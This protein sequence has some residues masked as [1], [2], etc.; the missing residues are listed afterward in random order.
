MRTEKE[1]QQEIQRLQEMLISWK[2]HSQ[3]KGP[4]RDFIREGYDYNRMSHYKV[5][6]VQNIPG[7]LPITEVLEELKRSFLPAVYPYQFERCDYSNKYNGWMVQVSNYLQIN[8][9]I[10]PDLE[11]KSQK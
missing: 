1:Y 11:E 8:M 3:G 7:D 4:R 2:R 9:S 5:Y 10:L 6:A